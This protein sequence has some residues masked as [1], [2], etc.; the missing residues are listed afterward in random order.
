MLEMMGTLPSSPFSSPRAP[1][2]WVP[3]HK[4][5]PGAVRV[6]EGWAVTEPSWTFCTEQ[7]GSLLNAFIC[8]VWLKGVELCV[9]VRRERLQPVG[10]QGFLISPMKIPN[11]RSKEEEKILIHFLWRL[12]SKTQAQLEI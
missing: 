4:G 11:R 9:S 1:V 5:W 2:L 8:P 6:S 3:M 7:Q 12:E 10:K